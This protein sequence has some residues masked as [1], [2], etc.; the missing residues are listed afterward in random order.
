M[1][2]RGKGHEP[3]RST[4]CTAGAANHANVVLQA[5][6]GDAGADGDLQESNQRWL[7]RTAIAL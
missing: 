3:K 5:R 1:L 7:H 6:A 4:G 2:K